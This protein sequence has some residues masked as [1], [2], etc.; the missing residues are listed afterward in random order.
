ME[1]TKK[2]PKYAGISPIDHPRRKT[3]Q[4]KGVNRDQGR[5]A[6]EGTIEK[7]N[8]KAASNERG[9]Q[10]LLNTEGADALHRE[11]QPSQAISVLVGPHTG[12]QNRQANEENADARKDDEIVHVQLLFFLRCMIS[13]MT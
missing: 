2:L 5:R 4:T 10:A 3:L 11:G 7:T 8:R 12:N 1:N 6:F 9:G 13:D